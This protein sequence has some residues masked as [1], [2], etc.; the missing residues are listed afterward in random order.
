MYMV[1][2]GNTLDWPPHL[3]NSLSNSR[4]TGTTVVRMRWFCKKYRW[5]ESGVQVKG[6]DSLTSR[7]LG[8]DFSE[9]A[10]RALL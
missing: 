7:Q 10:Q 3:L 6:W 1:F 2:K 4:V 9:A 5:R 8:W